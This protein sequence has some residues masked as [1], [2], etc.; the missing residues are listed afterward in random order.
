MSNTQGRTK[1][2][3][4]KG[5]YVLRKKILTWQQI[6]DL[7]KQSEQTARKDKVNHK[8]PAPRIYKKFKKKLGKKATQNV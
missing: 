6:T 7:L 1:L 3:A 4:P 8:F 5:T 2:K